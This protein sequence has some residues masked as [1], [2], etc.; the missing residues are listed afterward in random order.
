VVVTDQQKSKLQA[1]A[2]AGGP[3]VRILESYVS[4]YNASFQ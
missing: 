3:Q 1:Q 4:E 2:A